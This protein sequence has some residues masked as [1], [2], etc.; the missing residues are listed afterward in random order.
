MDKNLEMKIAMAFE[1]AGGVKLSEPAMEMIF[2]T[3]EPYDSNQVAIA[4]SRAMREVRGRLCPADIISRI[5]SQRP[6]ANEAWGMIPRSE[7]Q[8]TVW[9]DEMR[10][11]YGV[12]Y[13]IIDDPVAARMAFIEAYNRELSRVDPA[14]NPKWSVSIGRDPAMR[15][16]AIKNAVKMGRLPEWQAQ[17]YLAT[18]REEPK[19]LTTGGQP[20]PIG[21]IRS[22]VS[23]LIKQLKNNADKETGA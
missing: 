11:A 4:L 5:P 23:S 18:G 10:T 1:L 8:T 22:M 6:T 15:K 7:A 19:Q 21:E 3:L 20:V 12:A 2:E 17:K 16:D 14:T 13:P 9:T